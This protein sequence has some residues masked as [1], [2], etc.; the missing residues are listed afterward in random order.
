M[1]ESIAAGPVE[2]TIQSLGL[3]YSAPAW[4]RE[5][6]FG[7]YMHWGVYSCAGR[8]E[9]YPRN[10]YIP[11]R[12]A[13][14]HHLKTYGHPSEFG[15]KD[16]VPLWQAERFDPDKML[17]AIKSSGARYF[18][19]CA[20]H[21]D[22]FLLWDS[23]IHRWNAARMGPKKDLLGMLKTATE[24]AGLRWGVTTHMARTYSWLQTSKNSDEQGAF[25]GNDPAYEDFYLE[26]S[27]DQNC[28][29][30]LDPPASWR[31][32]WRACMFELI[33]KYEPD[34]LYFDGALPFRGVDNFQTGMDVLA[35]Y[36]N[37]SIERHGSLDSAMFIKDNDENC[38]PFSHG[39]YVNNVASLDLEQTGARRLIGVPWQTDFT[40]IKGGWSY[41][42][43]KPLY[44]VEFLLH[45]LI[46]VVSK[47]GCLLLNVPPKP[48]GT[49]E[50]RMVDLLA[51]MGRW[52][53]ANGEAIYGTLPWSRFGDG[54]DVR[55]TTNGK[56][57]NVIL[58][59]WPESGSVRIEGIGADENLPT[60][61]AATMIGANDPLP[62]SAGDSA[63]TV[64]LPPSPPAGTSHAWCIQLHCE[65]DLTRKGLR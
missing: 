28:M 45:L 55:F 21:H 49:F 23:A 59:K 5:A 9:W 10:M 40:V 8:N 33:D 32:H 61:E 24:R 60:V 62:M 53:A 48:D 63:V 46:D 44:S 35:H 26:K 64:E 13:Y 20:V 17:D 25:D 51:E 36:Y 65:R 2:P 56:T 19:P 41:F 6:K 38:G 54:E 30:P 39:L 27:D 12:P 18:T 16:L 7:I 58:R 37:R 14:E 15:Y 11:G 34:H 1:R 4:F 47:N 57:L 31:D 22:N 29:H 3:N 42:P 43:D 50:D 52:L